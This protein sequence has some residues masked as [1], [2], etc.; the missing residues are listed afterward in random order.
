MPRNIPIR[1]SSARPAAEP[2]AIRSAK[3]LS[4]LVILEA[5]RQSPAPLGAQKV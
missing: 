1:S 2:V 5:L 3:V 4:L